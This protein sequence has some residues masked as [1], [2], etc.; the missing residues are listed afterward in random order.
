MKI[1]I[2]RRI[3]QSA[4]SLL[5]R[6]FE[7]NYINENKPLDRN[8]L[9]NHI[10]NYE[11]VLCCISEKFDAELLNLAKTRLKVISNMAAGIDNIEVKVA[12]ELGI[13]VFNTPVVVTESTADLTLALALALIRKL[14]AAQIYIKNNKWIA[15]DPEIFLGRTLNS[16]TWGIVGFGQIGQAVAKRIFGFGVKV[17]YNDPYIDINCLN[18]YI[19]VHKATL[20][21]ILLKSDVVSLHIPLTKETT[22]LINLEKFKRMKKSAFL[23]NMARGKIVNTRDLISALELKEISGAAFD[24]FDPEPLS[25]NHEIFKFNNV[26]ITPHI[27]TATIDCR[28]KMALLAAKNIINFFKLKNTHGN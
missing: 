21:N 9:L 16:L 19:P 17:L 23:I 20:D 5:K 8:F 13:E 10:K 7:V 25:G 2:T 11:G 27:G 26:V 15:W 1:L 4:V 14:D 3:D 22:Q 28:R 12:R 6:H 18:G 24:V